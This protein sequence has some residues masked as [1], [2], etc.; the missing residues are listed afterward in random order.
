MVDK[1]LADV[2]VLS[3]VTGSS[4]TPEQRIPRNKGSIKSLATSPPRNNPIP[5]QDINM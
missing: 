4:V 3:G 5:N 1:I 2:S